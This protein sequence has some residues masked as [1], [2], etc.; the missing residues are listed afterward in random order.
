MPNAAPPGPP[1]APPTPPQPPEPP[2]P[3]R[4]PNLS[5]PLRSAPS[6]APAAW[7][8]DVVEAVEAGVAGAPVFAGVVPAPR[9]A[10]P[11]GRDAEAFAAARAGP[12]APPPAAPAV[13]AVVARRRADAAPVTARV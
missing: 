1:P 6:P 3:P 4:P 5:M 9:V 8:A 11:A 13:A 7:P 2:P 10:F 12:G